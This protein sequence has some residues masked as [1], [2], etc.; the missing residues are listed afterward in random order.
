M[1]P[2]LGPGSVTNQEAPEANT[3]AGDRQPGHHEPAHHVEPPAGRRKGRTS[4]A[5][6]PSVR[7]Q[8]QGI[9]WPAGAGRTSSNWLM[10]GAVIGLTSSWVAAAGAVGLASA[11]RG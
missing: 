7:Q 10:S 5:R 3:T 6:R 11:H 2:R 8:A 1:N 9:S 4:T